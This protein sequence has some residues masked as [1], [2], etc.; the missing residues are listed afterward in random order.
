MVRLAHARFASRLKFCFSYKKSYISLGLSCLCPY[1]K[2]A[3]KE[4][5]IV[6]LPR[7][8]VVQIISNSRCTDDPDQTH[9]R[10]KKKAL[11]VTLGNDFTVPWTVLTWT[12]ACACRFIPPKLQEKYSRLVEKIFATSREKIHDQSPKNSRLVVKKFTTSREKIRD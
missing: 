7:S 5:N 6:C 12:L 10:N 1:Q 2:E 3:R 8:H 11:Q 9:V 4:A